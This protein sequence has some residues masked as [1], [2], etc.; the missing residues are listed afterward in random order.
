MILYFS[1]SPNK[2]LNQEV[3]S[4]KLIY[5]TTWCNILLPHV[6]SKVKENESLYSWIREKVHQGLGITA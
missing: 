1:F 2:F 5:S 3:D 6:L 4:V